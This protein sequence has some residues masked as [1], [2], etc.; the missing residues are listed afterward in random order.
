[1][2]GDKE[3]VEFNLKLPDQ[4]SEDTT[5]DPTSVA[6]ITNEFAT[7]AF[8]FGHSLI[9]NSVLLA[10]S[11]VRTEAISCPIKDTFFKFEEFNIGSD[12]SGKAWQNIV[13]GIVEQESPMMDASI[14]NAVLDFLYCEEE[15]EIPGGFSEDL[16][17]RNIQRGRDHGLQ[18]YTQYRKHCGLTALT[19]WATRP[20]EINEEDWKNLEMAYSK[21]DDIDLFVGGLA[22][23]S[24][25]DGLVGPTF[26][27]LIGKQ[28]QKLMSG[29]RFFFTHSS[30]GVQ[31]EKG[32]PSRSKEIIRNRTL[33]D[34]ICDNTDAT[35]TPRRVMEKSLSNDLIK[36]SDRVGI[37]F[38]AILEE[39]NPS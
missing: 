35:R 23:I 31:N 21:V 14:N 13:R 15:C 9:P 33:G 39:L 38:G 25:D 6:D 11:P 18:P 10:L 8:R 4:D 29:D 22:E 1:M 27:C 17:A 36:C 12:L 24:N 16:A 7:A 3:I 26:G 34:I 19:D 2:L 30:L 20:E 37:D 28:F 32:L 5:Y